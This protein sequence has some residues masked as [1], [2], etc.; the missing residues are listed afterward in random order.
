MKS[1]AALAILSVAM[2][3][4]AQLVDA[5]LAPAP[6]ADPMDA[7]VDTMAMKG[8]AEA[9][10]EAAIAV[11]PLNRAAVAALYFS[12]YLPEDNV[13]NGWAGSIAGC[14]AGSAATAFQA[15][16]LE[17][18]NVYRAMAGLPGNVVLYS[19]TANQSADQQAALMMVANNALNHVPPNTWKCY[20][21]AAAD[22]NSGATVHSNLTLAS[23]FNY[24]GPTAIDGYMD[25]GGGGN[26][27]AG[28]RRW[29]LYPPQA[30]I[31]TGDVDGTSGSSGRSSNALWVIGGFN[32]SRPPTPNG[33][34]WPPR[35]Y[36]PYTMMPS[37]SNRWSLSIQNANFGSAK[38]S[39]TRNGVALPTPKIDP[40]E[41]NG[42]PSGS[43]MGDNTLV[44][45]PS[46]VTYAR[47]AQD[48]VYHVTVSGI[49]GTPA[50]VSYDVTM[51]D[52]ATPSD[53][54]F[55]DGFGD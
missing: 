24:N 30:H 15:A 27:G 13:T 48:V 35:G 37:G 11:D 21:A 23:G 51:F 14:N 41:S 2:Q 55:G 46:G 43:Y 36:I 4:N 52:P 28:H 29:L 1:L 39:M 7:V 34:A 32:A 54:I 18:V 50:S 45:E 40:F 3:A 26:E 25:D 44:W 19:G 38:V 10:A 33:I 8:L 31:A 12:T 47:P 5:S 42:Q 49:I 6:V 22:P 20:T 17:R 9:R 53:P 16:T